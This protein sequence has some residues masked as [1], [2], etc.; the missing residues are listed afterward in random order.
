MEHSVD[1]VIGKLTEI[2]AAAVR[3]LGA[4]DAKKKQLAEEIEEKTKRFDEKLSAE[5]ERA[6]KQVQEKLD[7]EK[8]EELQ[9]QKAETERILALMQQ[10]YDSEHNVWSD[11]I[12]QSIVRM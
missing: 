5:T 10:K 9:S 8:E 2:E 7:K 6:L 3:I 11:S 12:I 4:S 1:D